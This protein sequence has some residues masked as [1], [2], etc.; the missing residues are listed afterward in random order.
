MN[1]GRTHRGEL[2]LQQTGRGGAAGTAVTQ[3][4]KRGKDIYERRAE[5]HE[6]GGEIEC[7]IGDGVMNAV[8][9]VDP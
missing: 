1:K 6:V 2:E 8:D 4:S 7:G 5:S 3:R 9:V